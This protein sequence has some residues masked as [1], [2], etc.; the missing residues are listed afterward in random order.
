MVTCWKPVIQL[1]N[2]SIFLAHATASM[3]IL[4]LIFQT[5]RNCLDGSNKVLYM[6]EYVYDNHHVATEPNVWPVRDINYHTDA[7]YTFQSEVLQVNPFNCVATLNQTLNNP[8]IADA[9]AASGVHQTFERTPHSD[10]QAILGARV[11]ILFIMLIFEWVSASFALYY[12]EPFNNAADSAMGRLIRTCVVV[13]WDI[14]LISVVFAM[15][16]D[17]RW[18]IPTDNAII[19]LYALFKSCIIHVLYSCV[20]SK[21]A[22]DFGN[23]YNS[24]EIHYIEYALTAPILMMGVQSTIVSNS[25]IWPVQIA[26][27][28]IFTCNILG[29]P[30]HQCAV[31][32]YESHLPAEKRPADIINNL[33]LSMIF[34]LLASWGM[35]MS[36]WVNY[37]PSILEYYGQ[38]PDFVAVLA[39]SLPV[40][41]AAFG[42]AASWFYGWILWRIWYNSNIISAEEMQSRSQVLK[43]VFDTFSI[44]IKLAAVFIIVSSDQFGPTA[45][46]I[47]S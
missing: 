36:A 4:Y 3:F 20:P 44:A 42:V 15:I 35:F 13:S 27:V 11:N 45:G 37:I 19:G 25:A 29:I 33:G 17:P 18:D 6:E 26:Y 34:I 40:G 5:D 47:D 24:P 46:C 9:C 32:M 22:G 39:I 10:S 12:V 41:F 43:T 8:A 16:F 21:P 38:Y 14:L 30:L 23:V 7:A 28:G 1:Y 2:V 31:L